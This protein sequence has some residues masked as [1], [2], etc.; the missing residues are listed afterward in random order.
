MK[1]LNE[2]PASRRAVG[3]TMT[4]AALVITLLAV[5]MTVGSAQAQTPDPTATPTATPTPTPRF[6]AEPACPE[7]AAPVVDSGHVALFDVWWNDDEGELTNTSCPP[8]VRHVPAGRGGEAEDIRSPSSIDI[9]ET[10]IHIP[11]SARVDLSASDTPYTKAK[12]KGVWDAD[13]EE[14]PNGDGDRMVWAL[15]A[16]PPDGAPATDGL[17]LSFSAALLNPA[18]WGDGDISVKGDGKVEFHVDHIH[19]LD[20]GGQ[21]RRYVLAYDVHGDSATLPYRPVIDSR[22]VVHGRVELTPGEY[23]RPIWFFTRSGKYEFQMHVTGQPERSPAGGRSP[24]SPDPGVSSDVRKYLFHVGLMADLSVDVTAAPAD[25]TD[26][27]LDPGDNVTITITAGNAGPDTAT[28]TKVNVALP[29]GLTYSS[30]VAVTGT[31]Y[32][33]ASGVWTIGDLAKDVSKTLTITATVANGT[34]AQ[35]QTVTG[36]IYAIEEFGTVESL[37][38]DPDTSNNEDDASITVTSIPNTDPIVSTMCSVIEFSKPGTKVCDPVKVKDADNTNDTL[39]YGLTGDGAGHFD[40]RSVTAGAQIVVAQGASIE[41]ATRPSYALILTISDGKDAHGNADPSIDDS[42]DV[43][44][45]VLD[46][47]VSWTVSNA[48]PSLGE[49]VTFTV[50]L[51]NPPV[52]VNELS[53]FNGLKRPNQDDSKFRGITGRGNPG[54][55]TAASGR[56]EAFVY[57]LQFYYLVGGEKK[58]LTQANDITV[59]WGN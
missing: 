52:P 8:T 36:H 20:T 2:V 29:E 50:T 45:Q 14:N 41:Y 32:D 7:Q 9:A 3:I 26:T 59:R 25:S 30:A 16:C 53:Y 6:P 40:V 23:E 56:N 34:R 58:G 35:E 11:N 37:E 43:M 57:R 42:I 18:D 5:S 21:G 17:C 22:N 48:N 13:D 33:S 4:L 19:Q 15:P 47:K 44:I 51:E 12:Y 28:K 1:A 46:F 54:T 38:L 27:S 55:F 10:I 39:I 49:R 24:V 31:S